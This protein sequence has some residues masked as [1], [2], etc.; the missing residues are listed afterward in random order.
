MGKRSASLS[1]QELIEEAARILCEERLT[2]YRLAKQ[3]AAERLGLSLRTTMP[4]NADIQS[5]VLA[6]QQLFGG[7]AYLRHLRKLRQVALQAMDLLADFTP[8]LVGAAANG[9]A[10]GGHHVQLHCFSDPPET[11]DLFFFDRNIDCTTGE[12]RYRFSDGRSF[13]IPMLHFHAGEVGIDVAIFSE[14]GLRQSPLSPADGRPM[15]RL[16]RAAVAVLLE[17]NEGAGDRRVA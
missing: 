11:L 7:D 5:A 13:D 15:Q 6:Y 17:D 10:H 16:D 14:T 12:R 3:K 8:R 4:A 1:G 2:D 9:A